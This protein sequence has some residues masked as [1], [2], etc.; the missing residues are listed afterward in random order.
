MAC[1]RKTDGMPVKPT[2]QETKKVKK[3][4]KNFK[5]RQ[6]TSCIEKKICV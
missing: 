3:Q 6:K 5:N 2:S 1:Y 4:E